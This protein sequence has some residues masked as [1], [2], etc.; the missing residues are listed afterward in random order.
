MSKEASLRW[1]HR[2]KNKIAKNRIEK[3]TL[4]FCKWCL[5]RKAVKSKSGCKKC[6]N[7]FAEVRRNNWKKRAIDKPRLKQQL[8]D[9]KGGECVD[10]GYSKHFAALEFDHI[11]DDKLDAVANLINHMVAWS[12]VIAE[13]EKCDLVCANCHRIRTWE[14]LHK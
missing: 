1:Y 13:V 2:N 4:G 7:R 12:R 10:C 5:K 8:I 6:L 11:N 14:R 3:H 9:L